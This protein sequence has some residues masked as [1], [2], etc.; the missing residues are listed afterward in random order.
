MTSSLSFSRDQFIQCNVIVLF[1]L[2]CTAFQASSQIKISG[3]I[4]TKDNTALEFAEIVLLNKDS[5]GIKGELANED[6]SFLISAPAGRYTLLVRQFSRRF[7]SQVIDSQTDVK[8]GDIIISNNTHELGTVNVEVKSKLIERKPDRLVFNV[9]NAINAAGGD[10]LEALKITPGVR[11][12]NDVISMIGKSNLAVMIDDK[13][14]QLSGDDL[15]NYLRSIPADNIKSIDVISTPPAKYDAAG[16]SG[17][18]NIHLKK[19][20]R[21]SWNA[22]LS[23]TYLQR[24]YASS[25]S[26]G[27]FNY[28][29]NKFSLSASAFYAKGIFYKTEDDDAYFKDGLWHT[30]STLNFH[31]NRYNTNVNLDY[32]LTPRWTIGS[33]VML[34]LGSNFFTNSPYSYV[35]DYET[36]EKIRSLENVSPSYI[37]PALKSFNLYNEFKLDTTGRKLTVNMDYFNFTN[38]DRKQYEGVSTIA[39]PYSMQYFKGMNK[40]EQNITNLAA[41]ADVEYPLKWINLSFGGKVSN[42]VAKHNISS[43]NSG[44]VDQLPDDMV[45]NRTLFSYTENVE[46]LYISGNKKFGKKWESQLGLRTEATQIKTFSQNLDQKNAKTYIKLFPTAYVTYTANENSVFTFNYSRRINRP[47]F[48]DLNP[49]AYFLNPF[50][51]IEGNPFLQ[52]AFIDNAELVHA[53]KKLESKLYFSDEKNMFAQLPLAD[54]NISFIHFINE[55]YFSTKRFGISESYVFDKFG[56]WTS[57]NEADLNYAVV[58]SSVPNAKGAKGFNSRLTTKNDFNLNEA[59]TLLFNIT[60]FYSFRG[61][62]GIFTVLPQS[63]LSAAFQYLLLEKNLRL[64]LRITDIFRKERDR[65][66]TT[67]NGVYQDGNYYHDSQSVQLSVSYKF[68]NN[69]LKEKHRETGNQEERNRA[70][71]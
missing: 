25:S 69:K 18:V 55:N 53:Y 40:N 48:F 46:A 44:I 3:K 68:G 62:D 19:S 22:S 13:L 52:P 41:K 63:N 11:V 21:D 33:Q 50:Q 12:Q 29:K 38:S 43:Y 45:L 35:Y 8:L 61:V 36:G 34:N 51:I 57:T 54:S 16:N 10:A 24:M 66:R 9:E 14:I 31:Y 1:L 6:G 30:H 7:Y 58:L 42:A 15:I 4:V 39:H 49:N 65:M 20:R 2:V 32:Q 26:F 37:S 47:G 23:S 28:N 70:G 5:V 17:F 64:S 71:G 59:K 67:V 60:Y 27:N 56:W